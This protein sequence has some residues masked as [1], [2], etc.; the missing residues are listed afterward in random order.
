MIYIS[1][2]DEKRRFD[3]H[4]NLLILCALSEE[5]LILEIL[6]K[7]LGKVKNTSALPI[8]VILL[9]SPSGSGITFTSTG[10]GPTRHSTGSPGEI[11]V[12]IYFCPL[13]TPTG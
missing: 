5:S 10:E 11:S 2:Q 4:L 12:M 3:L 6:R 13:T 7:N 9:G 8:Y 1:E